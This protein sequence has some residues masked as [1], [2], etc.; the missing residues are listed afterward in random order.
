MKLRRIIRTW[1]II[2]FG[3]LSGAMPMYSQ[4]PVQGNPS[5]KAGSEPP[6]VAVRIVRESDSHVLAESPSGI[7]V[8]IGKP[9][10]R[11][12]IAES[13]RSLYTSGDYADLRAVVTPGPDGVRR[14]FE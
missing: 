3:L 6:V 7:F 8:E 13:L 9:L 10:D 14:A 2:A 4:L 1:G 11:G 12:K 5:D